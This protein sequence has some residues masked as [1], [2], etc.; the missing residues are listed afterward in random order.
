MQRYKKLL[1][2]LILT[3]SVLNV[4]GQTISEQD[5]N[6]ELEKRGI[7]KPVFEE[8]LSKRGLTLDDLLRMSP[9][10]ILSMQDSIYQ[11]LD[12]IENAKPQDAIESE[13][14]NQ[15]PS[16]LDEEPVSTIEEAIVE[17][18][19]V[20]QPASRQQAAI[21]GHQ[22]YRD[23]NI[24]VFRQADPKPPRNYIL[25]PGDEI[26][27]TLWG[28]SLFEGVYVI[29][30]LG[31]IKPQ[32]MP[33][34]LLKGI[35]YGQAIDKLKSTF[36][37]FFRFGPDQFTATIRT[38][39][40]ISIGIFGQVVQPGS[41]T[42]SAIN[43]A[44]NALAA[45]G[46]PNDIGS[47]RNI[48]WL[49]SDGTS[50]VIDLYEYLNNPSISQN[51]Y[52]QEGDIIQVPPAEK[53]VRIEG[54]VRQPYAYELLATEGLNELIDYAAGFTATAY[55]QNLQIS[56]ISLDEQS[57]I[58]VPYRNM[59][60]NGEN[61]SLR[62]G[63]RVTINA[64]PDQFLNV[65]TI[66]G[67]VNLEGTYQIVEGM[68]IRDVIEDQIN[69]RSYLEKALLKRNNFD[70][71]F[72]LVTF[73]PS[74]VL[75]DRNIGSNRLIRK[76]DAIEIY[77]K[78]RYESTY[79]VEIQG[80]VRAA[81][82]FPY[83]ESNQ[84]VA[85]ELIQLAGGLREDAHD[86]GFIIRK[87]LRTN[88][89]EYIQIELQDADTI[90]LRQDDV[91]L[92]QSQIDFQDEAFVTIQGA[93]RQGG[94]YP[95][96]E[97]VTLADL[98][99]LAKG[100]TINAALNRV[101]V[102]RLLLRENQAAEIQ[103]ANLELN[104]DYEI[105]G[106]E[107][108]KVF[109]YDIITIRPVPNFKF[110][111]SVSINGEVTYPGPYTLLSDEERLYD[112]IERAGGLSPSAFAAGATLY[113][114]EDS[115]GFIIIDLPAVMQNKNIASNIRLRSGDEIFIPK[116]KEF[117]RL[118]GAINARESL[119]PNKERGDGI[120]VAYNGRRSAQYY[121]D[122]YAAGLNDNADPKSI[123]VQYPNGKTKRSSKFLFLR[124][125]PKV[126]PGAVITVSNKPPEQENA[127]AEGERVDWG[128][129]LATTVTQ[130][131]AVLTLILLLDRI[132]E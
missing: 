122:Q 85:S 131:T 18:E 113:R 27:I 93:V 38:A 128:E 65:V 32:S 47:V 77:D 90:L 76:G 63:D 112:I 30:D 48:R 102:S 12:S 89:L 8:E 95:Y 132:S 59:T 118:I 79:T 124:F 22:F 80:A 19:P 67:A 114:P 44:L 87:S 60:T 40:T 28:E 105:I 14:V 58:D 111:R 69:E 104:A 98:I 106:S 49:K 88:Q 20:P 35:T 6:R 96:S 92:I 21:Y 41:Y 13:A 121:I 42:V 24:S 110:Q 61:V 37:R 45:A 53:V 3:A 5:I 51:F 94:R 10:E 117:V 33:R 125:S 50:K 73:R 82:S 101:E 23:G 54:Q 71:T 4:H 116:S 75:A 1:L 68:R 103:I 66:S 17:S 31:Y 36:S 119:D 11:V 52:L 86:Y 126:E 2:L 123:T 7:E 55:L 83:D 120:S 43:T 62:D 129:V 46:G 130:A 29:D 109:P 108:Y 9:A 15:I 25:G 70:G 127:E 16:S 97:N 84:L 99:K 56:R 39:R 100:T 34:I 107:A 91:L 74:D 26:A 72:E 78:A 81:G 64:I 115:T 57:L